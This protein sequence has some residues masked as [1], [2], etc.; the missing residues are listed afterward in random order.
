MEGD[1]VI[2]V[3]FHQRQPVDDKLVVLPGRQTDFREGFLQKFCCLIPRYAPA[4]REVVT[5]VAVAFPEEV[6]VFF[7]ARMVDQRPV[8]E[9]GDFPATIV[10][11]V[12]GGQRPGVVENDGDIGLGLGVEVDDRFGFGGKG[13]GNITAAIVIAAASGTTPG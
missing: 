12:S 8:G 11:G 5:G 2:G 1:E 7:P 6:A 13:G 3:I 4:L 9:G 10:G